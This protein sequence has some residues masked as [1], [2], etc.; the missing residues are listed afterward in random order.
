MNHDLETL[1]D[2]HAPS[3]LRYAER[4]VRNP[5][6]A[7]DVGVRTGLPSLELLKELVEKSR[8]P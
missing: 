2:L 5:H 6:S 8:N 7:Q 3:L 4:L 1:M